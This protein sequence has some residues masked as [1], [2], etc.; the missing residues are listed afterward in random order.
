M[1]IK[2]TAGLWSLEGSLSFTAF[3]QAHEF[4]VGDEL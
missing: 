4:P 1:D 2:K 3:P